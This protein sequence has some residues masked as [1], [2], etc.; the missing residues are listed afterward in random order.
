VFSAYEGD[1]I[2]FVIDVV[3]QTNTLAPKKNIHS[4]SRWQLFEYD[5][6]G[7]WILVQ[8]A[9]E[10]TGTASLVPEGI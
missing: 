6:L 1:V 5:R 7:K 2:Q 8:S 4:L 3:S 10:C 9:I